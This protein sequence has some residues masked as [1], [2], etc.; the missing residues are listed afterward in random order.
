M[1][2]KIVTKPIHIQRGLSMVEL[3]VAITIGLLVSAGL[4]QIFASSK[5][6]YRIEEALSRVQESGRFAL[7]FITND[8]R[9]A[10]YWGCQ[11]NSANVNNDLSAGAGYIDYS[12]S[13]IS[14]T[15]GGGTTPDSLTLNGADTTGYSLQAAASAVTTPLQISATNDLKSGDV[16]VVSDCS[17]GD[18]FQIT[19]SDPSGTGTV[20]HD[21]AVGTPGNGQQLANLYGTDAAVYHVHEI[22]YT[23]KAGADGQNALWRSVDGADQEIVDDVTNL[24]ILYGED[25][26]N[27]DSVDRYVDAG[28]V[29]DFNNVYSMKV[30]ITVQTAED[31]TSLTPGNRVTRN[32]TTT[33]AVRNRVL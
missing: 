29:T 11:S 7:N 23:V 9:M 1:I 3:M 4:I 20:E 14:G 10:S 15:D 32:F 27:D 16:V 18:I 17:G 31:Q 30:Q 12:G 24:Q 8:V 2:S 13:A 28:N 6:T 26:N 19:G 5:Q 21:L 33:V 22:I 25:T